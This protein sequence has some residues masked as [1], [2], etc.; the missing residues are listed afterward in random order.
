MKKFKLIKNNGNII[1]ISE[2]ELLKIA[3]EKAYVE[4]FLVQFKGFK[5]ELLDIL[6]NK[7]LIGYNAVNDINGIFGFKFDT[8]YNCYVKLV[9]IEDCIKIYCRRR[10]IS[11][12]FDLKYQENYYNLQQLKGAII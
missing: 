11:G 8:R 6:D 7:L 4:R 12:E 5:C 1:E 10:I 2:D 9:D 3:N